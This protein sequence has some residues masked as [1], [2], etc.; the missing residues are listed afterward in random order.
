M[1][2][3][4]GSFELILRGDSTNPTL[5]FRRFIVEDSGDSEMCKHIDMIVDLPSLD[6]TISALWSAE[7]S[8]AETEEGI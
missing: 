8:A 6:T 4:L 7:V 2:K 5:M 3:Q 1:A